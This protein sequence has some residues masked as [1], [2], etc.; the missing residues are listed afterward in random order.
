MTRSLLAGLAVLVAWMLLDV[1]I[2]RLVLAPIYE[3]SAS[4]WRPFDQMNVALIYTVTSALIAVF[5]SIY[6]LLVR[7]KS[8]GAGLGLGIFVGLALGTSVGFGTFIHMP[9]PLS[10]AWG[11]FLAS[12]VKGL[13]AGAIVGAVIVDS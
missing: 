5:V 6:K 1:L 3:A 12:L 13:V 11:W 10:L 8:F 9:I 7:P 4:L 2:H